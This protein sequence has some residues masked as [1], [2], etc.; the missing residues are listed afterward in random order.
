MQNNY[1]P[2]SLHQRT[3]GFFIQKILWLIGLTIFFYLTYNLANYV[4]LYRAQF[5]PIPHMMFEWEKEIPLIPWTIIP[6][7]S[8]NLF[9]GLAI[10]LTINHEQL[11]ILGKRLFAVQVICVLG[12]LLIPLQQINI[13]IRPEVDGFFGWWFDSLMKFDMPYNQAPSLHIALLMILWTYYCERVTKRLHFLIHIWALLIAVS[14]L[15]TWQHHFIDIPAGMLAGF[16]AIWC[17][18]HEQA[19]PLKQLW[20][21]RPVR[22]SSSNHSQGRPWPKNFRWGAV[23]G[24]AALLFFFVGYFIQG[25]FYWAYYPCV[26]F[27]L[28]S[29]NY[30]IFGKCGFPKKDCDG[31]YLLTD[32]LLFLPYIL[33]ARI[34]TWLWTRRDPPYDEVIADLYIGR[35]PKK[36]QTITGFSALVD[37]CFELPFHLKIH[38]NHQDQLKNVTN[39]PVLYQANYLLD[40]TPLSLEECQSAAMNIHV[41]R[42]QGGRVLVFCALGYSRSATSIAAYLICHEGYTVSTALETL[43]KARPKVRI[44]ERQSAILTTL[45]E[46]T[47]LE[48]Q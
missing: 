42:V 45:Y 11:S 46:N 27:V 18:P 10:L 13:G 47:L 22:G 3:K 39:T 35:F 5:I 16:I 40:M 44:G 1:L 37:C 21:T 29:L 31:R 6:Y 43:I 2:S 12:F 30:L 36:A 23:Y 34:N 7:W 28:V 17:F 4:T 38:R 15:T 14:V 48:H 25:G 19:S 20:G 41:A 33:V 9:Y 24:L 8:E 26:T 32:Y